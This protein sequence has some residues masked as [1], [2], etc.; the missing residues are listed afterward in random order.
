MRQAETL[1]TAVVRGEAEPNAL[2]ELGVVVTGGCAE[3]EPL[4][5]PGLPVVVVSPQSLL[6]GLV[7]HWTKGAQLQTWSRLM[8]G[9]DALDFREVEDHWAGD[10]LLEAI[11]DS[12]AGVE[13]THDR[14]HRLLKVIGE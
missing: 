14:V 8:L 6:R 3:F 9:L 1:M 4:E 5:P 13:I 10:D 2:G 7:A 11:W 12:S